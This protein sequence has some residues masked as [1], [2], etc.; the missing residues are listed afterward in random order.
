MQIDRILI[1]GLGSIGRRHLRIARDLLPNANIKVLRRKLTDEIPEYS[2]GV[3]DGID[4]AI[5]FAPQLAIISSPAP[6]HIATAQILAKIGTHLLIEKPLSVSV[7]G[8]GQLIETCR[9][10]G[11]IL[12][13]G[14]NLRYLPSLQYFRKK[15]LSE[16]VIG[17][18]LSVRCEAGQNLQTWRPEADYR[19]GVS[20]QKSLGGGVLLELSHE[21]DYLRWIFGDVAWVKAVLSRQS[22]LEIDVE[23]TAHLIMGFS[24]IHDGKQLIGAVSL[25]FIRYDPKRMCIAIGQK[26]TLRWDGLTGVVDFFEAGQKDWR[27]LYKHPHERDDSYRTQLGSFIECVR[28][29]K[30]P[31]VTSTDGLKV[32]QIIEA[33]RHSASSNGTSLVADIQC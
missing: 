19:D 20:S 3:F 7:D 25:D 28:E 6:Y 32:L 10:H 18:V 8:I 24:L 14:Y 11:V 29:N 12:S 16:D 1:V 2:N 21:I 30:T 22:A 9:M 15:I 26:G 27:E 33:I 4:D 17:K 31:L 13:I 5:A 23:D